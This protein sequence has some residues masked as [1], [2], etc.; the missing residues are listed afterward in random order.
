M[1]LLGEDGYMNDHGDGHV[2]TV[3]SRA[4]KL[5]RS[6][7]DLTPTEVF[8]L[9]GAIYVHDAGNS[10]GRER[11]E[12][13]L[14]ELMPILGPFISDNPFEIRLIAQIA[15]AHGGQ[16]DGDKDTISSLSEKA[17]LNEESVNLQR[18]AALLRFA[19]EIADDHT[20][21]ARFLLDQGRVPSSSV[22]HHRYSEA[23][24]SVN[25]NL[26]ERII[27]LTF[28]VSAQHAI[29]RL[30]SA[31]AI[32]LFD[33][34]L[35]RVKKVFTERT[36]CMRFLHT[37][38]RIDSI[39]V[40]VNVWPPDVTSKALRVIKFSLRESGYPQAPSSAPSD[41]VEQHIVCGA[42]L[43][44]DLESETTEAVENE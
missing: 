41:L 25:I 40:A 29:A 30:D 28:N 13:R 27:E 3:I 20:R 12:E 33:E 4:S 6:P 15:R 1:A 21:A 16:V 19:D 8:L 11:H 44:H 23:L 26:D 31:P 39:R 22:Q 17:A 18:I 36:Y 43:A 10:L 24:G 38:V 14:G 35:V 34:I 42:D 32:Y 9:L 5:L 2:A 37:L 7:D